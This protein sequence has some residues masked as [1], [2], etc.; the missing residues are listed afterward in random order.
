[1]P[2][3]AMSEV[4]VATDDEGTVMGTQATLKDGQGGQQNALEESLPPSSPIES[5]TDGDNKVNRVDEGYDGEGSATSYDTK[6]M[7]AASGPGPSLYLFDEHESDAREDGEV[8]EGATLNREEDDRTVDEMQAASRAFQKRVEDFICK[9]HSGPVLM[10]HITT[11]RKRSWTGTIASEEL[12]RSSRR[13][14]RDEVGEKDKSVRLPS[15]HELAK[16]PWGGNGTG[17]DSSVRYPD[18]VHA[19]GLGQNPHTPLTTFAYQSAAN[20]SGKPPTLFD[21]GTVASAVRSRE[22]RAEPEE[23]A[24]GLKDAAASRAASVR[25]HVMDLDAEDGGSLLHSPS[26]RRA[27]IERDH[28]ELEEAEERR[29]ALRAALRDSTQTEGRYPRQESQ[30]RWR[31]GYAPNLMRRGRNELGEAQRRAAIDDLAPDMGQ[32][33]EDDEEDGEEDQRGGEARQRDTWSAI[34][35]TKAWR[36]REEMKARAR[37]EHEDGWVQ[38]RFPEIE[39]VPRATEV[40]T[41]TSY[42]PTSRGGMR[43]RRDSM[44]SVP[45]WEAGAGRGYESFETRSH[46]LNTG[47]LGRAEDL[48]DYEDTPEAEASYEEWTGPGARGAIPTAVVRDEGFE[49]MPVAVNDPHDR[50]WIVHFEDPESPLTGLSADFIR[51]VW[52]GKE[53]TVVFTVFNYKYTENGAINRHIEAAVTNMTTVLTGETGFRVIPLDPERGRKLQ[54]RELPFVWAIRGLSEAGVWEMVKT[55][56]ATSKGVTILTHSRTLNNPCWVCGLDGFL[57]PDA[58]DIKKTVMTALRSAYMVRRLTDLTRS[59]AAL[60]HVQMERCVEHILRS[61]DIKVVT[62]RDGE[63]VA[64]VYITPPTDNVDAWREWAEEVRTHRFNAFICGA[65]MARR[66]FWC[67]GCRG[68]DHETD[69][70]AIP[71]MRGWKG[72]DAGSGSHTRLPIPGML[73]GGSGRGGFLNGAHGQTWGDDTQWSNGGAKRGGWFGPTGNG[74]GRGSAGRGNGRGQWGPPARGARGV[75]KLGWSPAGRYGREA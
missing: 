40:P 75:K 7:W 55:R 41:R 52:R 71:K 59:N 31:G 14:R 2:A 11:P 69:D 1:M 74:R 9:P 21:A 49:D 8:M 15:I 38:E 63:Y 33:G 68:V 60:D 61:L 12:R 10:D 26:L 27:R 58:E 62:T 70:C 67:A 42:A 43:N 20:V 6:A 13:M 30:E 29:Q 50:R 57:R 17:R 32:E 51:I 3:S 56:I 24:G 4:P 48:M 16:N 46:G 44:V 65:G 72:P 25:R 39:D 36:H 34:P 28:R 22:E 23:R 66:V 5:W 64:H 54:L 18:P 45:E 35:N 19:L 53:P 37:A 73:R 47:N